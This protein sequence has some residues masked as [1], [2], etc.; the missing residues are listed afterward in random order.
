M[1]QKKF[2]NIL[3]IVHSNKFNNKNKIGKLNY[4]GF[5]ALIDNINENTITEILAKK[6]LNALKELK[7]TEIKNK[8]LISTQKELLNLFDDLLETI[9]NN[10][11]NNNNNNDD[12]DDNDD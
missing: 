10:N 3:A 5:K 4:N 8:R 11:N 1:I 9:F 6:N 12:D 2:K 7:N